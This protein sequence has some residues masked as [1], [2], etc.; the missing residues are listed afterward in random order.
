MWCL[1]AIIANINHA[2]YIC[3][4]T[5]SCQHSSYKLHHLNV[6]FC[7]SEFKNIQAIQHITFLW[8]FRTLSN[9]STPNDIVE[10]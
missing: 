4:M 7:V 2:P 6:A 5:R 1:F 10:Q 3:D 9:R 8:V